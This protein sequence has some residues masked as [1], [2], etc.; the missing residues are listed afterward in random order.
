MPSPATN[1]PKMSL[2][3]HMRH[4]VLE[5]DGYIIGSTQGPRYFRPP[6]IPPLNFFQSPQSPA[7]AG[8]AQRCCERLPI[9]YLDPGSDQ[10]FRPATSPAVRGPGTSVPGVVSTAMVNGTMMRVPVFAPGQPPEPASFR[11]TI[12]DAFLGGSA[13]DCF[14]LLLLLLVGC[15]RTNR[16]HASSHLKAKAAGARA[17]AGPSNSADRQR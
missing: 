12:M 1:S 17:S 11:F 10:S 4:T 9:A 13:R 14:G 5:M 3:P 15:H 2:T 8:F 6:F 7:F 16:L